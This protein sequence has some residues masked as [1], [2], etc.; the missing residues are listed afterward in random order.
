MQIFERLTLG[1]LGKPRPPFLRPFRSLRKQRIGGVVKGRGS[2][3]YRVYHTSQT[4]LELL[5][6]G[7]LP[8]S[9][10]KAG[11][12]AVARSQLTATSVSQ[13]QAIP[14][15]HLLSSWDYRRMPP[16]PANFLYFSRYGVSPWTGWSQYP[17]LMIHPPRPPKCWDYRQAGF[18]HVTQAVLELLDSSDLPLLA[19]QSAG[20]I[21]VSHGTQPRMICVNKQENLKKR[22]R[23]KTW[24][25]RNRGA[26]FK[27]DV[28]AITK[29]M[30]KGILR[31]MAGSLIFCLFL[32]QRLAL[33]P[34]LE[35]SDVISAHCNLHLPGSSDS[36]AS[37]TQKS[38]SQVAEI[39][40][41]CHHIQL[42]FVFLV[43]TGFRHVGQAGL[44]LLTSGDPPAS[45]SQSARITGVSHYVQPNFCIFSRDWVSPWW[46]GWSRTPGLNH[47]ARKTGTL[48]ISRRTQA[49]KG[50]TAA[51][52]EKLYSRR[53][54]PKEEAYEQA[55]LGPLHRGSILLN[56]TKPL[57]SGSHPRMGGEREFRP[58]LHMIHRP[59]WN[60]PSLLQHCS[61]LFPPGM[62]TS[63]CRNPAYLF[64]FLFLFLRQSLALLPM[65]ERSS[66]ISANHNLRLPHS[67]DSLASASL[68]CHHHAWLSFVFLVEM[69]FSHVAQANLE[70]L[71]SVDS[72]ALAS[73]SAGITGVRHRAQPKQ[74]KYKQRNLLGRLRWE[75][76]LNQGG[77]SCSEPRLCH[78][79]PVWV[80]ERNSISKKK[81]KK[82]LRDFK[83]SHHKKICEVMLDLDILQSI[84]I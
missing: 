61:A 55:K 63:T 62:F 15:P 67:S 56:K 44:E 54:K 17:D 73:Q 9:A 31:T 25:P 5:T 48:V 74:N 70:L 78:C 60:F 49:D 13:I 81:K 57:P 6:S 50:T 34:R 36:T 53:G 32:R 47:G 14:L 65:L 66:A 18:C 10:P 45:A 4:G 40:G 38:A 23:E 3:R 2:C 75:N 83:C 39:T 19:S 46:P 1:L 37:A 68:A 76:N 22:E 59:K 69:G 27:R 20:I 77:G 24:D 64:L 35:C 52:E 71:T 82:S 51:R 58:S 43:E 28:K 16:L 84:H 12:S 7:Y 41:I 79:T 21:T 80:T 30:A 72:P 11:W 29:M 33:S 42:I 26:K 8:A